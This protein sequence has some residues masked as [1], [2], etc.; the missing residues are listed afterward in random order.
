MDFFFL[1]IQRNGFLSRLKYSLIRQLNYMFF[2]S[3][4]W[5][6]ASKC[7]L[8][9]SP[10][11]Q[12]RPLSDERRLQ[13]VDEVPFDEL[14][15][16]FRRDFALLQDALLSRPLPKTLGAASNRSS[17][18]NSSSGRPLTG[19]MYATLVE[20]YARAVSGPSGVPVIATAWES[21]AAQEV[22]AA[23]AEAAQQHANALV[24]LGA[25]AP[26]GHY[27]NADVAFNSSTA[28]DDKSTDATAMDNRDES[29]AGVALSPS[30]STFLPRDQAEGAAAHARAYATCLTL[31][32]ARADGSAAA[33]ARQ[34]LE[35]TM[36]AAFKDWSTRNAAASQRASQQVLSQLY[37]KS[38][39]AA[40][41]ALPTHDVSAETATGG[42]AGVVAGDKTNGSETVASSEGNLSGGGGAAVEDA[43]HPLADPKEGPALVARLF[44]QLTA[45][46]NQIAFG[47]DSSSS[48]SSSLGPRAS[49]E[50]AAFLAV[51]WPLLS[52][53]CAAAAHAAQETE[54]AKLDA[55]LADTQ[56]RIAAAETRDGARNGDAAA[57]AS[58]VSALRLEVAK[59]GAQA[60]GTRARQAVLEQQRVEAQKRASDLTLAAE[61][62]Q[63]ETERLAE[64]LRRAKNEAADLEKE[65]ALLQ[66]RLEAIPAYEPPPAACC[67][68]Q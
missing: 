32:D 4:P 8:S 19:P 66:D 60:D 3:Q 45:E 61:E 43:K 2:G 22:A 33:S 26:P 34:A 20:E 11:V 9:P 15:P 44:G 12:V 10:I 28:G 7:R 29:G 30:A 40:L 36:T 27:D 47:S 1:V 64:D 48:S 6:F 54:A 57:K 46:F 13:K 14:R 55:M 31:F 42:A 65:R 62:A 67:A 38:G 21:V 63:Q 23:A 50:L 52:A 51:K 49:A 56:R 58:E 53:R 24:A 5:F 35:A 68:L 41:E 37:T 59:L 17:G 16:E 18:N 39:L 25:D